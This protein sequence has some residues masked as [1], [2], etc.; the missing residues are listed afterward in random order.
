LENKRVNITDG[1]LRA[2]D[3]PTLLERYKAAREYADNHPGD[4]KAVTTMLE[5]R[6]EIARRTRSKRL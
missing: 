6:N 1:D 5:L 4:M 3:D 2:L